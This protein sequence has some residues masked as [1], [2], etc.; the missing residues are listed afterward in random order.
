[1]AEKAITSEKNYSQ[2]VDDLILE[3][4]GMLEREPVADELG[5]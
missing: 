4:S 3:L 5:G 2:E 1:M